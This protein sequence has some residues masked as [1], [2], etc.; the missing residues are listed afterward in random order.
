[1]TGACHVKRCQTASTHK[2][3]CQKLGQNRSVFVEHAASQSTG[4]GSSRRA[5]TSRANTLMSWQTGSGESVSQLSSCMH[6][7]ELKHGDIKQAF[8]YASAVPLLRLMTSCTSMVLGCASSAACHAHVYQQSYECAALAIQNGAWDIFCAKA[9]T[10]ALMNVETLARDQGLLFADAQ[11]Q[12][13]K[14]PWSHF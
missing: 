4:Q 1:M 12:E 7:V 9:V 3:S 2:Y 11:C 13:A 10:T 6:S 14:G 8:T 5:M